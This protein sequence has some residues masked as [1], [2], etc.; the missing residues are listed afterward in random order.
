MFM[1]I[2]TV[3]TEFTLNLPTTG[4]FLGKKTSCEK[5]KLGVNLLKLRANTQSFIN[6]CFINVNFFFD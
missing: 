2:Y 6:V 5:C 4:L 1:K 3:C